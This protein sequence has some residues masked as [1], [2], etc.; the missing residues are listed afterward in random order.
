MKNRRSFLLLLLVMY[1]MPNA[2]AQLWQTDLPTAQ[3]IALDSNRTILLVFS[4][5]DWCVPCMRLEK[6]IWASDVFQTYAKDH[7]VLVRA[8]FPKRKANQLPPEQ[9][10]KNGELAEK[11]NTNGYFPLVVLMDKN[12]TVLG[13]MGYQEVSPA[14]YLEL[15]IKLI[16]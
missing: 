4:G 1:F 9:E 11:Y 15:L 10:A 12:L 3:K 5:S 7:F 13:N 6:E 2:Q 16:P 8:D 14:A